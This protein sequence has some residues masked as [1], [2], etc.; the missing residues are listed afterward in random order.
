MG[1]LDR[2]KGG[3]TR[4][5]TELFVLV[6]PFFDFSEFGTP[7]SQ[8]DKF[9][10]MWEMSIKSAAQR[11]GCFAIVYF[12][13]I[14]MKNPSLEEVR[15]L[16]ISKESKAMGELVHSS[17]GR[18]RYLFIA[19]MNLAFPGLAHDSSVEERL[20]KEKVTVNIR[21]VYAT[22]CVSDAKIGIRDAYNIPEERIL[23]DF[24]ESVFAED[25]LAEE[26]GFPDNLLTR[27]ALY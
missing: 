16:Y 23:I 18:S 5:I 4:A 9:R 12:N 25:Y 13:D 27:F 22:R 17:F 2:L 6:H 7:K 15:R 1:L 21:G 19:A 24:S 20:D 10:S 8:W 11:P 3:N 14:L 26:H